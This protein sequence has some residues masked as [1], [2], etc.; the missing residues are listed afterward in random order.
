MGGGIQV[1]DTGATDYGVRVWLEDGTTEP[2]DTEEIHW[3]SLN[4][5][6][7]RAARLY[8]ARVTVVNSPVV[9]IEIIDAAYQ[10]VQIARFD[11]EEE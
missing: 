10:Q 2:P 5:A 8:N 7:K 3:V 6:R 9:A 11:E 4:I 1:S